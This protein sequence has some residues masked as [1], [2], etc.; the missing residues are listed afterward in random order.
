MTPNHVLMVTVVQGE[1]HLVD[2]SA[3]FVESRQR[4]GV[5]ECRFGDRLDVRDV[6]VGHVFGCRWLSAVALRPAW[7]PVVAAPNVA[8]IDD[9]ALLPQG[10]SRQLSGLRQWG[11]SAVYHKG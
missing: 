4:D 1:E 5:L 2:D 8:Q 3:W 10:R 9:A 11:V 7:Q 6:P